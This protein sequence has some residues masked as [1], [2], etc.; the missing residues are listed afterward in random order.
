MTHKPKVYLTSNVFSATEIGSNKAISKS[1]RNNIQE[2]WHKLNQ[3]SELNVFDG[4]FPT[5]DEI[6][7]EVE[8]YNPDILGCHLSHSITSEVLKN[9]K[10]FAVS[11]STAGYN[12]IQRLETDDIL[13]THTPGVL[14]ETV[15]DYTIAIIM[16]NLRNLIDLHTY[17]WN[18]QWTPDDKWDLDQSL[19]SVITNKILGI[20]GMGEIGKELVK[21]LYPWGISILYYDIHQMIDFEKKYPSLEFKENI[22]DVF[23][24]SDIVSLHVPLNKHT[25]NLINRNL[26]KLM[27]RNSLLVNTSR[28]HVLDLNTLLD[29]LESNEIHI[30]LAF[31]VFPIEPIDEMT[32]ERF[33]KIKKQNPEIR[34][35]LIP[36]NASAD[37]NIRGKMTI[38]FLEDILRIIESSSL[39]DLSDVHLIPEHRKQ[40][41]DKNW[42]ILRYWEK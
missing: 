15:A 10:L 33:K 35:T 34:M 14:H 13:I 26:L 9:S 27:K 12:H 19:S 7:K 29:M 41:N 4:R 11:T 30:N 22:E 31:D 40:L 28:G 8:E 36:H 3:I 39:D 17:V 2:L 23:I 32:L 18:G 1:I 5:E 21:K 42:R 25:E 6:Q 24:E 16:T 37:A 20:V 38:L